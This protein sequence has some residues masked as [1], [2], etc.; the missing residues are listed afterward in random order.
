MVWYYWWR[1]DRAH[2]AQHHHVEAVADGVSLLIDS[3]NAPIFGFDVHGMV[4]E[5]NHYRALAVR[6]PQQLAGE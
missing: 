3:M 6:R 2:R 5:C 1:D 4:T